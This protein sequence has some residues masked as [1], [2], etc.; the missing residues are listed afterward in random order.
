M[1]Q[2]EHNE[3][4][5]LS[6]PR[7]ECSYPPSWSESAPDEDEIRHRRRC[8]S[9]LDMCPLPKLSTLTVTQTDTHI[10]FCRS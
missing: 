1:T 5:A 2:E 3:L 4:T 8:Y 10:V 6:C 9:D 7:H